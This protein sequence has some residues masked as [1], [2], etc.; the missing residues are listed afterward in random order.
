M[1]WARRV[2]SQE[3]LAAVV[4]W[5]LV[6]SIGFVFI[7]KIGSSNSTENE[8]M[9]KEVHDFMKGVVHFNRELNDSLNRYIQSNKNLS[10]S[11]K[12]T[13]KHQ[14]KHQEEHHEKQQVTLSGGHKFTAKEIQKYENNF[15]PIDDPGLVAYIQQRYLMYPSQAPGI[16]KGPEKHFSQV[17]QSRCVDD[18]LEKKE[19]GFFIE[20]G[21]HDGVDKIG[22]RG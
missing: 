3:V 2:C 10:R 9:R 7:S 13:E 16:W 20:A 17:G 12:K 22:M 8:K 15:S 14:E 21:G 6:G 11:L 1:A 18:I 19:N 5:V 4:T